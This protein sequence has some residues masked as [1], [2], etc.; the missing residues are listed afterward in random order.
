MYQMYAITGPYYFD[1]G[2]AEL[3]HTVVSDTDNDTTV[4]VVTDGANLIMDHVTVIKE[5]YSSNLLQA[6]FFGLNAAINVANASSAS[7]SNCNI[8]THNGAAN[9]YGYGTGTVIYANNTDLYSSGPTAHGLY[10]SG[11]ATIYGSNIRHYSGGNRCSSFAGDSPGGYI[12]VSDSVAHTAGIG[13]GIFYA[14]GEVHGS[15]ILGHAE[16][17]PILFS[18]GPQ[19]ANI[20]DSD[21]TAGLLAGTVMFSSAVQQSGARLALTNTRLTTTGE[22]M[23]GLWFGNI[24]ASATLTDAEIITKS[25]ILVIANSSQVTQEFDYFA[26]GE[27]NSAIMPAEV[28]IDVSESDLEGDLVAYNGSSIS[29]ALTSHSTWTGAAVSKSGSGNFTITMDSTSQWIMTEDCEVEGFAN[30]DMEMKN[31]VSNGYSLR[32]N[33]DAATSKGLA[34]KTW[35]LSGGGE[36][37]PLK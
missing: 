8:T 15:N 32:Y 21:L 29:F 20:S 3:D 35:K 25:G 27:Q 36:V 26:G 11:N 30:G 17:S 7:I 28:T 34:K 1:N 6:S 9:V 14:L 22:D 19:L 5:G 31:V 23:A 33:S 10:A 12:Y 24:I 2:T 4:V 16:N 13:S 37:K 18:D